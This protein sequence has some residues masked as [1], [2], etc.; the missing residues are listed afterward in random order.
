M[1]LLI[2]SSQTATQIGPAVKSVFLL[3]ILCLSAGQS[4]VQRE[5]GYQ[6]YARAR[7]GKKSRS[8]AVRF[9]CS[10]IRTSFSSIVV[11]IPY[12]A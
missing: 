12:I 1:I 9:Y 10:R 7:S 4:V 3:Y 8:G 2:G 11:R 6:F 5:S